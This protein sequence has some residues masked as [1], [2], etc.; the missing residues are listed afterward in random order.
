[1]LLFEQA[2]GRLRRVLQEAAGGDQRHVAPVTKLD[3]LADLKRRWHGMDVRF[4][5]LAEPKVGRAGEAQQRSRGQAGFVGIAR[6][7]HGHADQGRASPPVFD[8]MMGVACRTISEPA[9]HRTTM[10]TGSW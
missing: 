7:E 6:S 4:V 5:R 10:R 8:A 3:R 9:A 1:M 2:I